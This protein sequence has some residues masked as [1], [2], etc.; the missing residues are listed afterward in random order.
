MKTVTDYFGDLVF[1][2]RVMKATLSAKVCFTRR[3][4]YG[5]SLKEYGLKFFSRNIPI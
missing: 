4:P 3:N 1:D 2:D 5:L